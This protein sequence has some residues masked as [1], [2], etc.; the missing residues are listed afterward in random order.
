M[1][2]YTKF[3]PHSRQGSFGQLA[4]TRIASRCKHVSVLALNCKDK[5]LVQPFL[6]CK[7][8]VVFKYYES[9]EIQDS[10]LLSVA[11]MQTYS[12]NKPLTYKTTA[13]K[14]FR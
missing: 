9:Y 1:C 7:D 6:P 3:A 12:N 5:I 14:D 8:T 11:K 2:S 4:R 13:Q 10:F